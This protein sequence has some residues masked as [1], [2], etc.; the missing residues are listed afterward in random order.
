MLWF[1]P[2]STPA[3]QVASTTAPAASHVFDDIAPDQVRDALIPQAQDRLVGIWSPAEEQCA[4]GFGAAYTPDG[5]YSQRDEYAGEEGRWR[6]DGNRLTLALTR[7]FSS[8]DIG[9]QPVIKQIDE[10]YSFTISAQDER[11]M[12]LT[13]SDGRKQGWVKCPEGRHM[14]L[15][16]QSFP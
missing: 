3:E 15:N 1:A 16:G 4:G 6:R 7:S 2:E 10:H 9:A 8:S 11:H 5:R 14:F 13:G 12:T